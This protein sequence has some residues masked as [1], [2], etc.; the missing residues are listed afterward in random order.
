MNDIAIIAR[1]AARF[2]ARWD[3]AANGTYFSLHWGKTKWQ[4]EESDEPMSGLRSFTEASKFD[5]YEMPTL[6]ND[7]KGNAEYLLT[8]VGP[9]TVRGY[10]KIKADDKGPVAREK[11]LKAYDEVF[12]A[13]TK[14]WKEEGDTLSMRKLE[15]FEKLLPKLRKKLVW[16]KV[17]SG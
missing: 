7:L 3:N 14:Q 4:I 10:A 6:E 12:D 16:K 2:A 8:T 15:Q 9:E 5:T 13:L 11:I 1:V 17:K